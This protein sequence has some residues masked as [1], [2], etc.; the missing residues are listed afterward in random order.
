MAL[1]SAITV[2]PGL[3]PTMICTVACGSL[4]QTLRI[5]TSCSQ[6]LYVGQVFGALTITDLPDTVCATGS[7]MRREPAIAPA[8]TT[9][10]TSTVISMP[11]AGVVLVAAA[12]G[13]A[14]VVGVV[15]VRRRGSDRI[16]ANGNGNDE[17]EAI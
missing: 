6:T 9:P 11:S 7:R 1:G 15:V 16:N 5:H 2:V 10:S 12:V 13:V 17:E 8:T 4:V 3:R 14:F